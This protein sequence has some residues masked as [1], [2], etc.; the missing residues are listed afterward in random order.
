MINVF[1]VND[2]Y[3]IIKIDIRKK[4]NLRRGRFAMH[5]FGWEKDLNSLIGPRFA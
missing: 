3:I 1:L 4:L 2:L 5:K